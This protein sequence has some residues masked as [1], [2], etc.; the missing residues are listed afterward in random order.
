VR[1]SAHSLGGVALNLAKLRNLSIIE[2]IFAASILLAMTMETSV[3]CAQSSDNPIELAVADTRRS[4]ADRERDSISKPI[5]VLSFFGVKPGMHVLDL[6]S[7]G[8]YYSEILSYAVGQSGGVVAH[9]NDIYDK[10]HREE[11]VKRYRD[12]RL[13]NVRRLSS[14]PP[15]LKLGSETFDM[16]VMIMVYHDVYYVSESNPRHPR[17][18]RDRFFAQVR[19]CLKPG[20][21]LAIVD[22]SAKS[23]TGTAA[24]QD[25]HRIDQEFARKDIEA[26]GFKFDGESNVLRNSHDDRTVLVFDDRIRG[27][28]DRFVYRFIKTK[29]QM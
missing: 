19:R 14:N 20:G 6:L 8:G 7:G 12:N 28:T 26:A 15:D 27:R 5:A 16:V 29:D 17:I 21:I 18:D 24:A 13:P 22:H 23:G 9:T 25:L 1:L 2:G 3:A 10:Y 4:E 11:I